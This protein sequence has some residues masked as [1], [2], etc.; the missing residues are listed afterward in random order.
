MMARFARRND[1]ARTPNIVDVVISK[2]LS[3][4]TY[5]VPESLEGKSR[6]WGPSWQDYLYVRLCAQPWVSGSLY[7]RNYWSPLE[8]L[9]LLPL[10]RV[11]YRLKSALIPQQGEW[12]WEHFEHYWKGRSN[13]G[14]L[15]EYEFEASVRR[16]VE[17]LHFLPLL[18]V[19]SIENVCEH[20]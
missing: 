3:S 18:L 15:H 7:V 14:R 17:W 12:C 19:A 1:A 5:E 9:P 13:P 6:P 10:R 2:L 11:W 20:S 8:A 4:S 16:Q